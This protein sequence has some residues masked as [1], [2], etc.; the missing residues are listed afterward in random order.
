MYRAYVDESIH[1]E[2]GICVVGVAVVEAGMEDAVRASLAAVLP[3]GAKRLHWQQNSTP[4]RLD[5]ALAVAE[6]V[7]EARAYVS[8][9]DHQRRGDAARE[10]CLVHM[11]ADLGGLPY[12]TVTIDRRSPHQ[13]TRDL[14]ALNGQCVR[15]RLPRPP[16]I[17]H[18]GTLTEPLL[19]LAD[20]VAG[21]VAE[22]IQSGD[23]A[24]VRM[25]GHRLAVV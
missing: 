20:T 16:R 12:E 1:V 9:F 25:F 5:S 19:W 6:N 23:D 18:D 10:R 7:V 17:V 24:F 13:D 15:L 8:Y 4:L 11:I 3:R 22:H 14:V 2:P 21:A